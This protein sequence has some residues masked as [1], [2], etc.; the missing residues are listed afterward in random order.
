MAAQA[1]YLKV[2]DGGTA[3]VG[4]LRGEAA[5]LTQADAGG[6]KTVNVSIA[7]SAVA[8]DG[9]EAGWAEQTTSAPVGPDGAFV[10]SFKLGLKPGKYTLKAGAVDLKSGKGSLATLPIEVPDFSKVESGADG[11]SHPVVSAAQPL[12]VRDIEELPAGT[13]PDPAHPFAAITLGMARLI[14][15]FG[16]T[17]HKADSISIF[18]QVYD[19]SPDHNGKADG[20]ATISILRGTAPVASARIP[21]TTAVGGSA[22][23]PVPLASY[24]PGKYVVQLKVAD[25]VAKKDLVHRRARSISAPPSRSSTARSRRATVCLPSWPRQPTP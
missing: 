18:F 3:L 16:T 15:Y 5:S 21:I 2:A 13:N 1:A 6:H 22:I 11:S 8:A 19:L 4:L 17:F 7:A 25:H 23:G 12:L 14:P 9:S 24:E 20:L 10:G